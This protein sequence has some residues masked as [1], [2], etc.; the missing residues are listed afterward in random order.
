MPRASAIRARP[1]L[2]IKGTQPRLTRDKFSYN[3]RGTGRRLFGDGGE[4]TPHSSNDGMQLLSLEGARRDAQPSCKVTR[5]VA[6]NLS[7]RSITTYFDGGILT[8]PIQAR[9]Y[10]YVSNAFSSDSIL[11]RLLLMTADPVVS[12]LM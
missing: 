4:A 12:A 8:T 6:W 7:N 11:S 5:Y 9:N 1:E 2:P 3:L 10:P